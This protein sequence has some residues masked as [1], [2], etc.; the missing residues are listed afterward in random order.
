MHINYTILEKVLVQGTLSNTAF[1]N[2]FG[3]AYK[4][5]GLSLEGFL[6]HHSYLGFS[7][8][9]GISYSFGK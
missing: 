4:L 6:S 1:F 5:K 7:P 2:R 8:Q 9:V 3:L